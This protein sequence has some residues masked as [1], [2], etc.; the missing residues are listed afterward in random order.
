MKGA[1]AMVAIWS[2]LSAQLVALAL[3]P[4]NLSSLKTQI[5][6]YSF[7]SH[8][9][10]L[11]RSPSVSLVPSLIVRHDNFTGPKW[12][13]IYGKWLGYERYAFIGHDRVLLWTS[14]PPQVAI[15]RAGDRNATKLRDLNSLLQEKDAYL[16]PQALSPDGRKVLW[17][18]GNSFYVTDLATNESLRWPAIASTSTFV[19]RCD[20]RAWWLFLDDPAFVY[21]DNHPAFPLYS[22]WLA[23]CAQPVSYSREVT[24]DVTSPLRGPI[25]ATFRPDP[26]PDKGWYARNIVASAG[27]SGANHMTYIELHVGG[28]REATAVELDLNN[29]AALVRRTKIMCPTTG[30]FCEERVSQNGDR[31]AYVVLDYARTHRVAAS[32]QDGRKPI[33]ISIWWSDAAGARMTRLWTAQI[34]RVGKGGDYISNIRWIEDGRYI[35]FNYN[36]DLWA[37]PVG[38]L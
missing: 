30:V 37:I 11:N 17:S 15:Y 13:W 35:G 10:T 21:D 12:N 6:R 5:H 23:D 9:N 4:V 29:A 24:I 14:T 33:A 1:V 38:P 3:I 27:I 8:G 18:A 32:E 26:Y 2:A 19:W 25:A 20:G 34:R 7:K 31:I 22:A 16:Q 36:E 28:A